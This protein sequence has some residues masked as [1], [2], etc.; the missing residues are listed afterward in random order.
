MSSKDI[1]NILN[2]LENI[3]LDYLFEEDLVKSPEYQEYLSEAST[4][5]NFARK[6]F[7]G[8]EKLIALLKYLHRNQGVSSRAKLEPFVTK[9][10]NLDLEIFKSHYDNFRLFK[11]R[12]GWAATRPEPNELRR[13]ME[14]KSDYD[15]S[16]DPSLKYQGF[17]SVDSEEGKDSKNPIVQTTFTT[18]RGGRY[19]RP[20]KAGVTTPA[21]A[22]ILSKEI[23]PPEKFRMAVWQLVDREPESLKDLPPERF[24][25]QRSRR[26]LSPGGASVERIK[27]DK[28]ALKKE[29]Q[30]VALAK[31]TAKRLMLF[32]NKIFTS[33]KV[34]FDRNKQENPELQ[35]L[36]LATSRMALKKSAGQFSEKVKGKF[37]TDAW[38]SMVS[39]IIL[40]DPEFHVVPEVKTELDDYRKLQ[41]KIE[42]F[43][44]DGLTYKEMADKLGISIR[45]L[46]NILKTYNP[47]EKS[48]SD[49]LLISKLAYRRNSKI[50]LALIKF[51]KNK[52]IN[53]PTLI[54]K[55]AS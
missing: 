5:I 7:P 39:D 32:S 3:E 21:M 47:E 44:K 19:T 37:N 24:S 30:E 29:A 18:T 54:K 46:N 38:I 53:N 15:P 33:V 34:L 49:T 1:K 10:G 20:E 40:S 9:S 22:D 45:E 8:D 36:V 41:A 51:I 4:L 11:G 50:T 2:L 28:R 52:L 42:Q 35:K 23:N 25:G 31:E 17:F 55:L 48:S 14:E 27:K 12:R 13:K 16:K 6:D 26:R 43:I